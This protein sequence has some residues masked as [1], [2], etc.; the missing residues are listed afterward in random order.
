MEKPIN[1]EVKEMERLI[2][3]GIWAEEWAIPALKGYEF[4][5]PTDLSRM[6]TKY[7]SAAEALARLPNGNT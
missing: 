4:T 5:A 6:V 1:K 2:E 3:L 7:S